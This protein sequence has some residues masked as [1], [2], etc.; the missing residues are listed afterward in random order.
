YIVTNSSEYD[1]ISLLDALPIFCI[2][3]TCVPDPCSGHC[4][5]RR[6]LKSLRPHRLGLPPTG[7]HGQRMFGGMEEPWHSTVI[8]MGHFSID[9]I[10]SA[11]VCTPVSFR[12][13]MQSS[14]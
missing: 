12:S 10:G 3:P 6:K 13:R 4:P 9:E 11:N 14:A 5:G 7:V 8:A 1:S 2:V